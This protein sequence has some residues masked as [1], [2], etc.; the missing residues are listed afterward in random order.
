MIAHQIV[1]VTYDRAVPFT[2]CIKS[3]AVFA[4]LWKSDQRSSLLIVITKF[5]ASLAFYFNLK[6][7]PRYTL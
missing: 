3:I 6:V 1:R 7:Y 2:I 4:F 5:I